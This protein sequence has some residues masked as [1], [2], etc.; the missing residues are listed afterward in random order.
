MTSEAK[1]AEGIFWV[2]VVDWNVRNFHGYTYT[3]HRGTTYNAYLIL[4]EKNTLIDTVYGPFAGEMLGR[5][6]Q[7]IDPSRIAY[8]I[9]NHV[10]MDH[11]G[12]IPQVLQLAPQAK[13][14][15]TQK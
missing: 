3:T 11:S 4:D 9:A 8:L 12:S 13:V 7:V 6:R 5:I 1:L 15:R 2:G 10:E 14:F